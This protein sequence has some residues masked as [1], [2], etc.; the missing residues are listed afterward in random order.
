MDI[1]DAMP[2]WNLWRCTRQ[3]ARG[4]RFALSELSR[5][6]LVQVARSKMC[7]IESRAARATI[8]STARSAS[9]KRTTENRRPRQDPIIRRLP[10]VSCRGLLERAPAV[11][12]RA[13]RR[14]RLSAIEHAGAA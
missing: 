14:C 11:V 12:E 6:R 5:N 3:G 13:G 7:K 9:R 1:A 4:L 8:A 10:S 2:T